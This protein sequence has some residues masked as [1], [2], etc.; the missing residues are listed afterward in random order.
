MISQYFTRYEAARRA[1][2]AHQADRALLIPE[3][4]P[5]AYQV[6]RSLS[7]AKRAGTEAT[8][9]CETLAKPSAVLHDLQAFLGPPSKVYVSLSEKP[10]FLLHDLVIPSPEDWAKL[11][12]RDK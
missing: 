11:K 1:V 4:L 9:Q 12:A 3:L 2:K 8:W 7:A 10:T 6:Y 5:G